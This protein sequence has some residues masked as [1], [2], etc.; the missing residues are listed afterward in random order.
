MQQHSSYIDEDLLNG[1][2]TF[3]DKTLTKWRKSIKK[4]KEYANF[5]LKKDI[6]LYTN[7]YS[8]S[9]VDQLAYAAKLPKTQ[10]TITEK[11]YWQKTILTDHELYESFLILNDL[12]K[13]S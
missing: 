6:N 9:D 4:A 3:F 1:T 12:I 11:Q 2:T 13:E 8:I 10:Y 5:W 7:A